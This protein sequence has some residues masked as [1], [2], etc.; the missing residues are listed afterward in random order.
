M[1]LNNIKINDSTTLNTGIVYDISKAHGGSTYIDLTDALGTNGI[2]VPL[3]V[4]E[5]GMSVK[6]IQT[7]DN[8]SVN[9]VQY[10]LIKDTWSISVNDWQ[11]INLERELNQLVGLNLTGTCSLTYASNKDIFTGLNL[12]V[13]DTLKIKI[14][15]NDVVS[16]SDRL[17]LIFWT[18]RNPVT[19]TYYTLTGKL[20]QWMELT[21][22][23]ET[24]YIGVQTF[25]DYEPAAI[26]NGELHIPG[27]LEKGIN[28]L[29]LEDVTT[30]ADKFTKMSIALRKNE[31][32]ANY[33]IIDTINLPQAT[34]SS[35]GIISA[36]TKSLIDAEVGVYIKSP[37]I[38]FTSANNKD[39]FDD[40]NFNV[41]DSIS[42]KVTSENYSG[43]GQ[44]R[45]IFWTSKNPI[46]YNNS[47]ILTYKIG[48]WVPITIPIET[49]I[50][51]VQTFEPYDS[52][53]D[54]TAELKVQGD[55]I[56]TK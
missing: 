12:A 40:L 5:G 19:F 3:E 20:G 7:S 38:Y 22:P 27:D 8:N 54:F 31:G 56:K 32:D 49:H 10:L 45:L 55:L 47:I 29:D 21:V 14:E 43:T 52:P 25:E 1:V 24:H 17:N 35:A 4:R 51:G 53:V 33:N 41:G 34:G 36:Y 46:I 50:I 15:A 16:S 2:N 26:F 9:Y 6:F 18:S 30:A 13:G 42:I 28:S 44:V 23:I 48:Q 39:I 11:K 37:T